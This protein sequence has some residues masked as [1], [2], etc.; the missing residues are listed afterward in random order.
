[1]T[2]KIHTIASASKAL[3]AGRTTATE[4]VEDS[5]ARI[6]EH[7]ARLH[8]FVL[9]TAEAARRTARAADAAIKRGKRLAVGI[10]WAAQQFFELCD[11]V[12]HRLYPILRRNSFRSTMSFGVS[13]PRGLEPSTTPITPRPRPVVA[14]TTST[15]LAVAQKM[16]ATS[17][18]SLIRPKT[19][20]GKPPF[21]TTRKV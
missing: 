11:G 8:S 16:F 1:M 4:L 14:M 10:R 19:L 13:M 12:D 5:L 20:I 3:A 21:M 6:A 15:G 2:G 18:T 7:D 17:G 9:L